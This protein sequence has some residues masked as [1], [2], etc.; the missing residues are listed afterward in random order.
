MK[1]KK[2][3]RDDIVIIKQLR[4]YH[5]VL[6]LKCWCFVASLSAGEES[7]RRHV[8]ERNPSSPLIPYATRSVRRS[9]TET[10][11]ACENHLC[12]AESAS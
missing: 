2:P 10:S 7:T 12:S 5:D 4:N 1:L 11:L 8:L 9:E 6:C 3:F